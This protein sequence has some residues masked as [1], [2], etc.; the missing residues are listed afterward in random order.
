MSKIFVFILLLYFSSCSSLEKNQ[1][2]LDEHK[3]N[4]N[5]RVVATAHIIIEGILNIPLKKI[6]YIQKSG[7]DEYIELEFKSVNYL[8][9]TNINKKT[10][11]VQFYSKEDDKTLKY[12]V[13]INKLKRLNNKRVIA[14]IKVIDVGID[15]KYEL[16]F[17]NSI[18]AITNNLNQDEVV[19]EIIKQNS[20]SKEELHKYYTDT[21]IYNKVKSLIDGMLDEKRVVQSYIELE[22]LGHTATPY[23]IMQMDDY[24]DLSNRSISL[25]VVNTFESIAHYSPKKVVDL[26]SIVLSRIEGKSFSPELANGGSKIQRDNEVKAW[27]TW[28]Y[29]KNHLF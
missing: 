26:L 27:I 28:L 21:R 12:K 23:I 16:F 10:L 3:A 8:K 24:R 1:D 17:V 7:E 29:K 19:A 9:N 22:K 2:F 6:A 14:Y 5:W 15:K 11:K 25:P 18:D 20:F 4:L 13:P